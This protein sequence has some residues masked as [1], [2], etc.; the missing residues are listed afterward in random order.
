MS[1]EDKLN[2]TADIE[3]LK[4]Q[5]SKSK[6]NR[7]IIAHLWSGIEKVVTGAG[8]VEVAHKIAHLITPFLS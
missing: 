5:L 8:M 6:P 7:D 4:N 1:D 3:S 2:V